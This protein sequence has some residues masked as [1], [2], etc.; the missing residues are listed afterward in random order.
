MRYIKKIKLNKK[1]IIIL[2]SAF[3]LLTLIISMSISIFSK[4]HIK[5]YNKYLTT[6][7]LKTITKEKEENRIVKV[8]D[9]GDKAKITS[10]STDIMTSYII[11][12]G[13][14]YRDGQ[15]IYIHRLNT[16]YRDLYDN[17]KKLKLDLE[18][19]KKGEQHFTSLVKTKKLNNILDNLFFSKKTNESALAKVTMKSDRFTNFQMSLYDIDGYDEVQ[20]DIDFE[21]LEDDY[22]I[23]SSLVD[24]SKTLSG[25]IPYKNE[26]TLNNPFEF[27]K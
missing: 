6:I 18:S 27:I 15:K 19:E 17:L 25:G 5:S 16:S 2:I 9:D 13:L 26:E 11:G 23:D 8:Y 21:T 24:G 3:I 20:I 12:K 4:E 22:S 1:T 7:T 14:F 10:S